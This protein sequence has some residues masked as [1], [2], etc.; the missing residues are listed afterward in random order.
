MG[1]GVA[2]IDEEIRKLKEEV[3]VL[4]CE[5]Q[6]DNTGQAACS[7]NLTPEL[8]SKLRIICDMISRRIADSTTIYPCIIDS[9]LDY[10]EISH[11]LQFRDRTRNMQNFDEIKR[12]ISCSIESVTGVLTSRL[13]DDG[14][15]DVHFILDRREDLRIWTSASGSQHDPDFCIRI[16]KTPIEVY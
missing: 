8:S 14:H 9:S 12:F 7:S 15:F 6:R 11:A 10:V 13:T 1:S 16:N 2:L 5:Y 3:N 4:K